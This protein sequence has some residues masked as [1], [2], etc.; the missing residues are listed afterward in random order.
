MNKI[1]WRSNSR[2]DHDSPQLAHRIFW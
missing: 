1:H 2:F